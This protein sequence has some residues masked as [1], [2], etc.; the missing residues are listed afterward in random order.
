M[1]L[2]QIRDAAL[3]SQFASKQAQDDWL[4]RVSGENVQLLERALQHSRRALCLGPLQGEGYIFLAELAFLDGNNPRLKRDYVDQALRVRPH[5]GVVLMAA[6][7][8]AAIAGDVPQALDYWRQA[9]H[10][11]R[12]QQ[13][14]LIETLA[15]QLPAQDF[16]EHFQPDLVALGALHESY[17]RLA[18]PD[19][20]QA[21]AARYA[22]ALAAE[23]AG[24]S[25]SAAAAAWTRA[26]VVYHQ[27]GDLEKAI[28][29]ARGAAEYGPN[30]FDAHR[31]L[32]RLLVLNQNFDEALEHLQ[33]CLSRKP[34]DSRL[35]ADVEAAARSR[36]IQQSAT[37][38]LGDFSAH[39]PQ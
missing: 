3:A 11:D 34:D 32:A 35:R 36:L 21:V 8:E 13:Q 12:E 5:S 19:E 22:P 26:A 14:Q 38:R 6:G 20:A 33:W 28:D 7:S 4:R 30:D 29:C 17:R 24:Q 1:P 9:F 25:G 10:Q 18:L 23:A 15:P 31:L 16:L 37:A 27:F 2:A 39:G